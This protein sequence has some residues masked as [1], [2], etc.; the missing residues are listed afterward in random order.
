MNRY[1]LYCVYVC[2]TLA[3]LNVAYE[4][5]HCFSLL[6]HNVYLYDVLCGVVTP[7]TAIPSFHIG[8]SRETSRS[9]FKRRNK[10]RFDGAHSHLWIQCLSLF[11][12]FDLSVVLLFV[13]S[14]F[15][16][17]WRWS[18]EGSRR[19]RFGGGW[20]RWRWWWWKRPAHHA[21]HHAE[22]A[23]Q[24][25]SLP[26]FERDHSKGLHR[27]ASHPIVP[28]P[29]AAHENAFHLTSTLSGWTP[30]RQASVQRTSSAMS[31]RPKSWVRSVGSL[32]RRSR[33]LEIR[34]APL[35]ASWTWC[36]R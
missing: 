5:P 1:F 8:L 25:R 11:H 14:V 18:R 36:R 19:P 33:T 29:S 3:A 27:L 24:G 15:R 30:T 23:L 28:P 31:S 4:K 6:L 7:A 13:P 32:R 26:V 17:S 10:F 2:I 20:R 9:S 12:Q 21:V 34:K 16:T 35:K 22:S